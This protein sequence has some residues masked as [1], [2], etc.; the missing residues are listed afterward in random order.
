MSR[1]FYLL[2]SFTLKIVVVFSTDSLY[3]WFRDFLGSKAAG[4][5]Y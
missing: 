2:L 5:W 4:G 3:N 1:I